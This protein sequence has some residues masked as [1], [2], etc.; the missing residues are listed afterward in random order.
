MKKLFA[1][2]LLLAA[3]SAVAC[4]NGL[5][6]LGEH[7]GVERCELKGTY[8][9]STVR[10][11]S[12]YEYIINGGVFIG[13]D[14]SNSSKLVIEPGVVV[15]GLPGSFIS[16]MRGSKIEAV[17]TADQPIRFT[18]IKETGRKRGE[19]GG[20]VLN[21][22]AP[23][24]ACKITGSSVCEAMS[25]GIKERE[26]KFGG[27]NPQ[28][29]S[30]ILKYVIVEYVGYPIAPDNE[31]NGITFNGVGSDT[32]VDYIQVHMSSDDGIEF[33]GGTVNAKHV[34]LSG[35]E[36]D[37]MDWDFGWNGKM[38]FVLINQGSDKVDNGIEADNL[39]S[40]MNATPRS[41]PII[42]NMTLLGSA[43]SSYGMLLRRGTGAQL[44]NV[45]VSGF[46]KA[47][48]DIDDAET[49][50]N[51]AINQ[52]GVLQATGL[53]MQ[54]S[55]LSCNKPFEN[56]NGDLFATQD[57]YAAQAGNLVTNPLLTGWMPETNSP[58]LGNGT[59]LEDFFFE[60]VDYIGAFGS[61]DWTQ[62]WIVDSIN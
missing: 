58:A 52:N 26:V 37:S 21:G 14:N 20:L 35:N 40:P 47:C 17:G 7:N 9:S 43:Q 53:T 56:E 19:W 6:S 22:N 49:F 54:H 28:D 59:M 29:N 8:L 62:G 39:A 33:F 48:I 60:P 34:V 15:R 23:I 46:S 5:T 27:A 32:E 41:N 44:S 1:A 38:Q 25:E 30:G 4:P 36:D 31:L 55:I 13:D 24:N 2:S 57:W 50:K 16:I 18:S 42:S 11:T 45:I 3:S 10:L 61:D 51:A 12:Q